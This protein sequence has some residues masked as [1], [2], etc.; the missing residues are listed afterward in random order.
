[1]TADVTMNLKVVGLE[2]L[3]EVNQ[4]L[5]ETGSLAKEAGAVTRATGA[6][7]LRYIKIN[8]TFQRE[9][10]ALNKEKAKGRINDEEYSKALTELQFKM[11]KK[12]LTDQN[13]IKAN[14]ELAKREKKAGD[15]VANTAAK[16]DHSNRVR[17]QYLSEVY[18]LDKAL[19]AGA[20]TPQVYAQAIDSLDKELRQFHSGLANG[21]NQFARYNMQA[22]KTAQ[23][24]KR[25]FNTGLQQ[26]GYQVGDFF[27]QI[28][29][30]QSA[31]VA[32]GQQGSQLAGIFGPTGAVIGGL[33]AVGTAIATIIMQ[34]Q[35]LGSDVKRL[36]KVFEKFSDQ[37]SQIQKF[38]SVL[39]SAI[40]TPFQEGT[41]A[42]KAFF[43]A[44]ADEAEKDLAISVSKALGT[45]G[46][47]S[48]TG[49]AM[50]LAFMDPRTGILGD[51]Q[52]QLED[53]LKG[54]VKGARQ[55]AVISD[56]DLKKI[57]ALKTAMEELAG[58]IY[59]EPGVTRPI[60]DVVERLIA[61]REQYS[62]TQIATTIDNIFKAE[63]GL[64]DIASNLVEERA[65]EARVRA[66]SSQKAFEDLQKYNG[67]RQRGQDAYFQNLYA[68][69]DRVAAAEKKAFIKFHNAKYKADKKAHDLQLKRAVEIYEERKKHEELLAELRIK[70]RPELTYSGR[71]GDPRK[72][73]DQ[74][75]REFGYKSPD[76]IIA[77]WKKKNKPKED[78]RQTMESVVAGL[79]KREE[80]ERKL[81]KLT[82]EKV[83]YEKTLYDLELK[84]AKAKDPYTKKELQ[85]AATKLTAIKLE[86]RELERQQEMYENVAD[87]FG[88]ML[89]SVVDGT[90]KIEDAF[91]KMALAIVKD[92]YDIY[93]VKQITGFITGSL[94][95]V[96]TMW[97]DLG[98]VGAPTIKSADGGGYTGNGPR[99]GG[100][101]GKG[102]FMAML[103]PRETVIDH[104]KGGSSGV[105]VNQTINVST[106]VQQ[107]VRAEVMG[108][109]PQIAAASK[110]AVLDAKRR[111]GAYA[112]AF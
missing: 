54:E 90:T 1:M 83:V 104:T 24:F 11:Q 73:G 94:D 109:M 16:Y 58:A 21:A 85:D 96:G 101:D 53:L 56:D 17:A 112:G 68:E 92:L 76:Q 97:S 7:I 18:K 45:K 91:K 111:G 44:L 46:T 57:K 27:V 23:T 28:Q 36:E 65:E 33:L 38:E 74:Y 100:L 49:R 40:V 75:T 25:R 14:K 108:L 78:R 64:Q 77:E 71:G 79:T 29:S 39:E 35:G 3:R 51:M 93:V 107:T 22:Y 99:S 70:L 88:E 55:K 80:L 26:A 10:K 13:L 41:K 20:I 34:T 30:G 5:A 32:L 4:Q 37:V 61:L 82:D 89:V 66:A 15:E 2:S 95:N 72:M 19:E 62:G 31:L 47:E 59:L 12:L 87:A 9:L 84:N 50:K 81:V 106:G 102:G 52:R 43:K 48:W 42:A 6:H 103:H 110:G 67:Y 86:T 60:E 98:K 105:V 63:T 8:Q 69:N